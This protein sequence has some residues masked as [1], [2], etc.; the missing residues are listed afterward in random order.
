MTRRRRPMIP[1]D[2]NRGGN[3][4]AQTKGDNVSGISKSRSS[5]SNNGKLMTK[6]LLLFFALDEVEG[7][8]DAASNRTTSPHSTQAPK[9]TLL[10]QSDFKLILI[11]ITSFCMK[12]IGKESWQKPKSCLWSSTKKKKGKAPW[13]KCRG[14]DSALYICTKTGLVKETRKFAQSRGSRLWDVTPKSCGASVF[15]KWPKTFRPW[16]WRGPWYVS[17]S[18]LAK[19]C[20][21]RQAW[22]DYTFFFSGRFISIWAYF[23]DV[24]WHKNKSEEG[25][26]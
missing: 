17:L 20:Y 15:S 19:P 22:T 8:L 4:A 6:M 14:S 25:K 9:Q 10:V 2:S 23:V 18:S 21:L 5:T 7:K 3:F 1:N 13:T 24:I 16:R 26:N 12:P 11:G